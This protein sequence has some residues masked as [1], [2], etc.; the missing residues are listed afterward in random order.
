MLILLFEVSKWSGPASL[1]F[2]YAAPEFMNTVHIFVS[3]SSSDTGLQWLHILLTFAG[4]VFI[5]DGLVLNPI[6]T[7]YMHG[8]C[9]Q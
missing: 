1:W 5:N 2:W 9:R 8:R 3:A 4:I 6:L 7:S